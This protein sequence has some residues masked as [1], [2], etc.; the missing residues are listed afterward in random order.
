M[1]RYSLTRSGV[2]DCMYKDDN[3]KWVQFEE[4]TALLAEKDQQL[5]E[6]NLQV[7]RLESQL[8]ER[9]AETEY[10]NKKVTDLKACVESWVKEFTIK[11]QQ[12]TTSQQ[13]CEE[14]RQA[15]RQLAAAAICPD[16]CQPE[17]VRKQTAME[18]IQYIIDQGIIQVGWTK[19]QVYEI[20]RG[21]I[22]ELKQRYGFEG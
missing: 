13:E 11:H 22:T 1:Q 19:R 18:I 12:L 16:A 6:E 20:D 21:D 5:L 15:N 3:G 14:L 10:L 4:A 2:C 8:A 7:K 9:D 17:N